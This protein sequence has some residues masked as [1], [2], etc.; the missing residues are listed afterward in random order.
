MILD[1]SNPRTMYFT[2]DISMF[3]S[4][5]CGCNLGPNAMKG[6]QINSVNCLAISPANTQNIHVGTG[7]GVFTT[8]AQSMDLTQELL[9]LFSARD[10]Q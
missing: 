2:N 3:R 8:T 1:P 4:T 5:D 10:L 6:S 7:S 9:L